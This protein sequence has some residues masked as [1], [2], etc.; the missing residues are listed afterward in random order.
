MVNILYA[1]QTIP[2]SNAVDTEQL[3]AVI[4]ETYAKGG[5]LMDYSGQI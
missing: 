3:S 1:G 2:I 4:L 5:S